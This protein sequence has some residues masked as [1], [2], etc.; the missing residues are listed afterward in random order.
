MT[1]NPWQKIQNSEGSVRIRNCKQR[2]YKNARLD[3]IFVF[4]WK[5]I[6]WE[7]F[8][9]EKMLNVSSWEEKGEQG[10]FSVKGKNY[11]KLNQKIFEFWI[12]SQKNSTLHPL[13][14]MNKVHW[15]TNSWT[16]TFFQG[17][18][19]GCKEEQ[20]LFLIETEEMYLWTASFSDL[21]FI[22]PRCLRSL[23]YG[24]LCP[25]LTDTPFED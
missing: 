9:W 23:I 20:L 10:V 22:G 14:H 6:R 3:Q 19:S 25:S 5:L 24:S 11:L 1:R 16:K 8:C 2:I 21:V 13:S 17:G 4:F 7:K 15:I 12:P 18:L